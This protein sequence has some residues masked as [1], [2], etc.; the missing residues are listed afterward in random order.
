MRNRI[1]KTGGWILVV[2]GFVTATGASVN[3]GMQFLY[4]TVVF[5][6]IGFTMLNVNHRMN[7]ATALRDLIRRAS[8]RGIQ[9]EA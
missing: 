1:L 9:T 5:W 4:T 3:L 2:S 7:K 6:G 8:R